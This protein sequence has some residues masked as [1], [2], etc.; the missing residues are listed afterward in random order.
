MEPA[1]LAMTGV[2]NEKRPE[3]I[4]TLRTVFIFGC[5]LQ[6]L[7]VPLMEQSKVT[8]LLWRPCSVAPIKRNKPS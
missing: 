2:S 8:L 7:E 4:L 3:K 1:V 6:K 5:A